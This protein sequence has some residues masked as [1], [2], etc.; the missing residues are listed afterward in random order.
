MNLPRLQTDPNKVA[1]LC[2][3]SSLR[4]TSPH[5]N[6]FL[7]AANQELVVQAWDL[8]GLAVDVFY[9]ALLFVVNTAQDFHPEDERELCSV[10]EFVERPESPFVF[11]R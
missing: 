7:S 3:H 2:S 8:N 1:F 10:H 4:E 11:L 5:G 6:A 9:A